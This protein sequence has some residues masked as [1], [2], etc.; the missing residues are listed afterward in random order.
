[1]FGQKYFTEIQ[2]FSV[3]KCLSCT[4]YIFCG[5][6][7]FV[8]MFIHIE[9]HFSHNHG[10]IWIFLDFI[11]PFVRLG[12]LHMVDF[13]KILKFT[14]NHILRTIFYLAMI[15]SGMIHLNEY[16][17]I[18]KIIFHNFDVFALLGGLEGK[19]MA[20]KPCF[21]PIFGVKRVLSFLGLNFLSYLLKMLRIL[22]WIRKKATL[23]V[24]LRPPR[25]S[26]Y[27]DKGRFFPV[28][29]LDL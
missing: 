28:I 8:Y 10:D 14:I 24:I 12:D 23:G 26:R 9:T 6:N 19:K 11:G 20:Q 18:V 17:E 27:W 29:L 13:Y 1:M 5:A 2:N 15:F 7:L 3:F 21:W 4:L 22:L 25:A 16:F